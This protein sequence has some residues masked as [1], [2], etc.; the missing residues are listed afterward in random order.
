MQKIKREEVIEVEFDYFYNRDGECFSCYM[1]PKIPVTDERCKTLSSDGKILYSC[2]LASPNLCTKCPVRLRGGSA[3]AIIDG[4]ADH[5]QNA[6]ACT[7]DRGE[8]L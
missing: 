4:A 6:A 2:L 7:M 1:F 5:G 8:V 3:A